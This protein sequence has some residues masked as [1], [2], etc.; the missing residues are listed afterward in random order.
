MG[1][2]SP[3][4]VAM[5]ELLTSMKVQGNPLLVWEE[6]KVR[7]H[8]IDFVVEDCLNGALGVDVNGDRWHRWEK[9]RLCDVKKLAR[10]FDEGVQPLVL[11]VWWSRLQRSPE[12]V[13]QA[14]HLGLRTG[15]L[16]WWDWAVTAAEM[17]MMVGGS[18]RRAQSLVPREC[19]FA[20]PQM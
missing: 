6:V 18:G 5:R 11:G 19:E 3:A 7:G 9:V 13:E 16:A 15:R 20:S 8:R 17:E 14:V 10:V 1:Q 4:H 2:P 12:S